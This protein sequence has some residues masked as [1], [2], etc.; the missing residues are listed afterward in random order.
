MGL[1]HLGA[2]VK[3]KVNPLFQGVTCSLCDDLLICQCYSVHVACVT[4]NRT[5]V[6]RKITATP[7]CTNGVMPVCGRPWYPPV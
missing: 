4:I 7:S 2:I 3:L 5:H 6:V 1:T